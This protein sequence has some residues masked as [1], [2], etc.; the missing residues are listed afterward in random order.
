MAKI[1][2]IILI[3]LFVLFPQAGKALNFEL[4]PEN[5]A[6]NKENLIQLRLNITNEQINAIELRLKFTPEDILIKDINDANSI[7]SFWVEKPSFSNEAGE[8]FFSGIVPGGYPGIIPE[9]NQGP[10]G[11]LINILLIP[12]KLGSISFQIESTR[13]LLNDGQG[14]EANILPSN[15]SFFVSEKNISNQALETTI[16]DYEP[17]EPFEPTIGQD[18]TVFEGKYFVAFATQDKISGID[19]YEVGENKNKIMEEDDIKNWEKSQSPYLLK[20]QKLKSYIYVKAVDKAGNK[21]IMMVSPQ[22]P[23]RWYENFW[24]WFIIILIIAFF[25][26]DYLLIKSRVKKGLLK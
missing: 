14:S 22:N 24:L 17:P 16:K 10:I 18:S 25:A 15:L 26:L 4:S 7:I 23:P 3:S 19:H 1:L 2:I 12:K 13:V 20:D 6:P 21:R 11:Q 9:G 8:I 5:L